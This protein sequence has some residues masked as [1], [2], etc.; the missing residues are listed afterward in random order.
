MEQNLYSDHNGIIRL[1]DGTIIYVVEIEY[2][3]DG[4]SFWEPTYNANKHYFYQDNRI[5]VNGHRYMRI[6][7]AGDTHFQAP[8]YITA[9][10]GKSPEI[11]IEG[12]MVQWGYADVADSWQDLVDLTTLKGEQGDQGVQGRGLAVTG[13]SWYGEFINVLPS[14]LSSCNRGC[15]GTTTDGVVTVLSLGDGNHK[16]LQA[17]IDANKFRS[18]DGVLYLALGVNDLGRYTRFIADDANGTN[19]IDYRK[20]NSEY[21]SKGKVYAF[22]DGMWTELSNLAVPNYLVAAKNG[23]PTNGKFMEDYE[24]TTIGLDAQENLEVKDDSI[25]VAKFIPSTFTHGLTEGASI[26]VNPTEL[27][28]KGVWAYVATS[29]SEKHFQVVAVDIISNGLDTESLAT[30]DGE[31][32]ENIIV[33]V[34]DLINALSGLES[35]TELDGY[36]DLKVKSGDAIL[37]DLGGVNVTSD[38]VTITTKDSPMAALVLTDNNS[39]GVQAKHIHQNVVNPNKGLQKGN[40]TAT[41]VLGAL[42]IK[43]DDYSLGFDGTGKLEVQDDGVHGEHLNDDTV[44]ELKGLTILDNALAVKLAGALQFDA[45]GNISIDTNS[46]FSSSLVK[47]INNTTGNLTLQVSNSEATGSGISLVLDKTGTVFT[48][49]L[50]VN[51]SVLQEFV[52]TSLSSLLPAHTHDITAIEGLVEELNARVQ[53]DYTYGGNFRIDSV[54]GAIWKVPGVSVWYKVAVDSVGNLDTTTVTPTNPNEDG[55]PIVPDADPAV[56]VQADWDEE[57]ILSLAYIKNKPTIVSA[58]TE[59]SDIAGTYT[60]AQIDA[61]LVGLESN[62]LSKALPENRVFIGNSSGQAVS[63]TLANLAALLSPS[64]TIASLD[65]GNASTIF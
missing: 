14:G 11:R 23:N 52:G 48:I 63:T 47:S 13:A 22:A 64:I 31:T 20:T 37:V 51:Q 50:V 21:S 40:G 32:N 27:T 15:N 24:S 3:S 1:Y 34:D 29:D 30:V 26:K 42:E 8:M 10:D 65:G 41:D 16:I 18:D 62:K 61:L 54:H 9:I 33:N 60:H 43:V 6:R 12:T 28:G 57:S 55:G 49:K 53:L 45:D 58:H 38:E 56:Q 46:L 7:H 2:S 44:N 5:E 25:G 17:D 39:K 35:T 59:L 36:K 4:K 19:Y